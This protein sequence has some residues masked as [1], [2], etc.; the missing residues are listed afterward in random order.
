MG[1]HGDRWATFGD[2]ICA[3]FEDLYDENDVAEFNKMRQKDNL[4]EYQDK[5]EN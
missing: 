3:R 4:S 1:R 2:G 5:F